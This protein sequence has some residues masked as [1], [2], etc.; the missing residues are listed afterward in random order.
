[1]PKIN[2]PKPTGFSPV[3]V[4]EAEIVDEMTFPEA[5]KEVIRGQKITRMEWN[6]KDFCY[7]DEKLEQLLIFVKRKNHTWVISKGD[8]MGEDWIVV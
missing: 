3:P 2:L 7:L 1:M 6:N 5:M 4:E 8:M